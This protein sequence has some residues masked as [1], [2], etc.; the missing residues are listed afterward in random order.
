MTIKDLYQQRSGKWHTMTIT[1]ITIG[2]ARP[3]KPDQQELDAQKQLIYFMDESGATTEMTVYV[4]DNMVNLEVIPENLTG[5]MAVFDIKYKD[6]YLTGVLT[7]KV[8]DE[9]KAMGPDWEKIALGKCRHGIIMACL[10]AGFNI[11]DLTNDP[12]LVAQ[13]RKLAKFS[14]KGE[15]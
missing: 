2:P 9:L 4:P 8:P 12:K 13:V 15:V 10:H 11:Y 3:T 5:Q 6:D 7:N 14:Y 1:Y